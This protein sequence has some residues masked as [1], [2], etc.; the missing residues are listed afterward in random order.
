MRPLSFR[1]ALACAALP[2]AFMLSPA[3]LRAQSTTRRAVVVEGFLSRARL[4]PSVGGSRTE[5]Q[6]IGGRVLAALAPLPGDESR[7]LA[8]RLAVGVFANYAPHD[9]GRFAAAHFGAVADMRLLAAPIGGRLDPL[10]SLGAGAFRTRRVVG[11]ERDFTFDCL[12]P[13]DLAPDPLPATCI[14]GNPARTRVTS[15]FALSPAV[16]LR[17]WVLPGMALRVDARDVV[18]YRGAP[19][20]NFELATGVSFVR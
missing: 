10:L 14:S 3:P 15:D 6:G 19:R 16:A 7:G 11:G 18:V 13:I 1:G 2:L 8:R 5:V 20:H 12:R 9:D 17:V 4:D